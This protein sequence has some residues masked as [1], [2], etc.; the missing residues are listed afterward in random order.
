MGPRAPEFQEISKIML[1]VLEKSGIN[2]ARN[3]ALKNGFS[4]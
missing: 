3:I 4:H 1:K 2:H